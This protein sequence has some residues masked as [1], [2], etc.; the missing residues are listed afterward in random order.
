MLFVFQYP[1]ALQPCCSFA[2]SLPLVYT[3]HQFSI[4]PATILNESLNEFETA[5]LPK[6]ASYY[7]NELLNSGN[8]SPLLAS[9]LRISGI[10]DSL[11]PRNRIKR[12]SFQAKIYARSRNFLPCTV[13]YRRSGI[14]NPSRR[15]RPKNE[16]AK[17]SP[18][19][20][21][22]AASHLISRPKRAATVQRWQTFI[23]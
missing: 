14:S 8:N 20:F 18:T 2:K 15:L 9:M 4:S 11:F 21:S 23:A 22:L 6:K 16:A 10:I 17:S 5:P 7:V 13:F 3:T 19:I 12:P 1:V